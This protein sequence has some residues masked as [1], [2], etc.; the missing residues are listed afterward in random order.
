MDLLEQKIKEIDDQKS[1]YWDEIHDI[2]KKRDLMIDQ[3]ELKRK[4]KDFP[5][6][7]ARGDIQEI[8]SV[9]S[10]LIDKIVI[11]GEDIDIYWNF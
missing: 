3:E 6:I 2:E 5:Y 11:T 10:D 4:A 7:I 9:I 8:R 1:R